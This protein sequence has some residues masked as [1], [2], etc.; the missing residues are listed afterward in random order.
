M[1]MK[2]RMGRPPIEDRKR[3]RSARIM[4]R[5]TRAERGEIERAVASAGVEPSAWVRSAA[6]RAARRRRG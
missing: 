2:V 6:L 5:L 4:L 1:V 3:V